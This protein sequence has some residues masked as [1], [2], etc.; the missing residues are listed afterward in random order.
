MANFK[1]FSPLQKLNEGL[2]Q[3]RVFEGDTKIDLLGG[4]R[5]YRFVACQE[6]FRDNLLD[7]NYSLR[8]IG[9]HYQLTYKKDDRLSAAKYKIIPNTILLSVDLETFF[10]KIKALLDCIAFFVPFYFSVPLLHQKQDV[11]DLRN[12]WAFRTMKKHFIDGKT[13]DRPFKII[14]SDNNDWIEDILWKRDVLYHKFHRLSVSQ[15]YWTNSCYA[16]LYEFNKIRDFIPDILSYVSVAYFNL[17]KFLEALEAHFKNKCEKEI[18]DYKYFHEGSSFGNKM[19]KV[20]YF[21]VSF[22][23]LLEGKILMRIHPGMRK[24]IEARLIP[25]LINLNFRCS[26]C[27]K[28]VVKVKPTVENF[29]LISTRCACGNIIPLGGSVSKRFFPFFF[30]RNQQYW[31]LV[32]VYKIEEKVTF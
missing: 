23:R 4:R 6:S 24:E 15:D 9:E 13:I 31:S 2:F 16:Y 27:K 17:V 14:L 5:Y 22:G 26:K 12:P 30:N 10:L 29:V 7:L 32:P 18:A 3:A 19:D 25:I 8:R 21:F 1:Y 28:Y 11:K 20:H